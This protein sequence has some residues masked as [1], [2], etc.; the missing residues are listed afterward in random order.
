MKTEKRYFY[1]RTNE[2]NH[3]I[4][5]S[6]EKLIYYVFFDKVTEDK[7][8]SQMFN[9]LLLSDLKNLNRDIDYYLSYAY[10]VQEVT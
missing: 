2:Y 1:S 10:F 8:I 6:K 4:I 3:S 9:K 7:K 5:D